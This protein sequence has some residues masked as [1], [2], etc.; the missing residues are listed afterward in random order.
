MNIIFSL[1]Q[2]LLPATCLSL[3]CV[4]SALDRNRPAFKILLTLLG[5][6]TF[7]FSIDSAI[8]LGAADAYFEIMSISLGILAAPLTWLFFEMSGTRDTALPFN[9]VFKVLAPFVLLVGV[10]ILFFLT[11]IAG[12]YLQSPTS[13]GKLIS[14]VISC[15]F[16]V[17]SIIVIYYLI[18]IINKLDKT[19]KVI[20]IVFAAFFV[21]LTI[22]VFVSYE[23]VNVI[24][25]LILTGLL[26][27]AVTS[28]LK[29]DYKVADTPVASEPSIA[30]TKPEQVIVPDPSK[31]D[32]SKDSN[33]EKAAEP[34]SK[35]VVEEEMEDEQDE[36]EEHDESEETDGSSRIVIPPLTEAAEDSLRAKFENFLI[37]QE[38]FLRPGLTMG[39]V[40]KE[41]KTNRTYVSQLVNKTYSMT[42]PEFLN[43][44][45]IDYAEQYILHNRNASQQEVARACGFP[46]ASSFN[47]TFKKITGVTPRIWLATNKDKH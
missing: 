6:F 10:I 32:S 24:L 46:S 23:V 34:E 31:V 11:P 14:L 4:V 45:R 9:T 2:N 39:D 12:Q 30:E 44:L 21:F 38:A 19:Y 15:V 16:V 26:L 35:E 40:A 37:N 25:N 7:C 13:S 28:I 47:V 20:S 18:S 5:V 41:L 29:D 17:E 42:F 22:R 1:I 3:F 8:R 36:Q 27:M 43:S 33:E